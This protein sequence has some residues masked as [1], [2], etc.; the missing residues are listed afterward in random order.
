MLCMVMG[1]IATYDYRLNL[2]V[3]FGRLL[4]YKSPYQDFAGN[5]LRIGTAAVFTTAG[6]GDLHS[7]YWADYAASSPHDTPLPLTKLVAPR[8]LLD[9][10]YCRGVRFSV[11]CNVTTAQSNILTPSLKG[12]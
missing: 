8:T 4:S 10:L 11:H 3:T 6:L 1:H 5:K 7:V 2:L 9:S 12:C